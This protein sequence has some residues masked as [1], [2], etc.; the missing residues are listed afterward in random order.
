MQY[1]ARDGA[2]SFCNC[3]GIRFL[4]EAISCRLVLN[5]V[6]LASMGHTRI[7]RKHGQ[8]R[9]F[10]AQIISPACPK[11]VFGTAPFAP[12]KEKKNAC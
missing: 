8:K 5:G 2:V 3:T 9:L 12:T 4:E 7:T 11:V 1:G 10:S 6:E